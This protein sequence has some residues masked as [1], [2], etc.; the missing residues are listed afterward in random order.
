M[1]GG[2]CEGLEAASGRVEPLIISAW[3]KELRECFFL[4]LWTSSKSTVERTGSIRGSFKVALDCG[5]G[6]LTPN[7]NHFH[8]ASEVPD[9]SRRET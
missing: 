5:R 4:G 3:L 1:Y 6:S 2:T 8:T 9:Y 7:E